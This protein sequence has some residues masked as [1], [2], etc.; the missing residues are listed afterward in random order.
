MDPLSVAASVTGLLLAAV[1]ISASLQPFV[2]GS[3]SA[4]SLAQTIYYELHD[5]AAVLSKLQP[6][7]LG[8]APPSRAS[9]IDVDQLL[10]TL[11]G[12]VCTFSELEKEVGSLKSADRLG[13]W[14]RVKWA[15]AE[16]TISQLVQRIQSHKLS[17][18]LMLSIF[19]WYETLLNCPSSQC[20]FVSFQ[21]HYPR[22]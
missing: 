16:P 13:V 10:I 22:T 5:F 19:T 4:P 14:D 9:M 15:W 1:Q 7:V 17:L 11:T 21:S 2:A 6:F 8:S 3:S 12:C 20:N 18:N